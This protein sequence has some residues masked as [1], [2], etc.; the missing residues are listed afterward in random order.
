MAATPA[1]VWRN[2]VHFLAFGLGS[3]AAPVAPGTFGTLAAV[4]IYLTLPSMGWMWYLLMLLLTFVAGIWICGKTADDIGVHDHGG[5]VWD[6][7]V[8]LWL[9]MFLAPPGW[10]WLLL[11]F[12]LFRIFDVL[13]PWPIRW[14]DRRVAGGFGIMIDDILAGIFALLCLQ[15]AAAFFA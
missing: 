10:V 14:L 1:S 6:E 2:P 12:V 8:G 3:G 9:T 5:I 7:F 15:I 4:L 11:G 13:K